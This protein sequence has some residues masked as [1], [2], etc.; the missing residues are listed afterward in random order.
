MSRRAYIDYCC[1]VATYMLSLFCYLWL[2]DISYITCPGLLL[3]FQ[4]GFRPSKVLNVRIGFKRVQ[5][6]PQIC[7]GNY[8][9]LDHTGRGLLGSAVLQWLRTSIIKDS[10][11][12]ERVNW[13]W[14]YT[15]YKEGLLNC[16]LV[17]NKTFNRNNMKLIFMSIV[18]L[19]NFMSLWKFEDKIMEW[20]LSFFS[21]YI[22]C[23]KELGISPSK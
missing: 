15:L 10:R 5:S 8:D 9:I 7:M 18:A 16:S 6:Y 19:D 17:L 12:W 14:T 4:A 23:C 22:I 2:S 11:L 21:S 20:S 1:I 3:Y 13:D